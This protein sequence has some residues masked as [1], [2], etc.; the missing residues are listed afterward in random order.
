MINRMIAKASPAS[1]AVLEKLN[2]PG[3]CVALHS[4]VRAFASGRSAGIWAMYE[5][6]SQL[7]EQIVGAAL[8]STV[9]QWSLIAMRLADQP[10]E[11]DHF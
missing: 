2:V 8:Q 6:E 5:K 1:C 4:C 3:S 9:E 7:C 10:D 11:L